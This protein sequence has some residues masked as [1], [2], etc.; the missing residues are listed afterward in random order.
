MPNTKKNS[1]QQQQ[2]KQKKTVHTSHNVALSLSPYAKKQIKYEQKL[3]K[4]QTI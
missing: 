2:R 4:R 1:V 3:L